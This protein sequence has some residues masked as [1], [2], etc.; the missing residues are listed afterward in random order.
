MTG[1]SDERV[2]ELAGEAVGRLA[3]GLMVRIASTELTSEPPRPGLTLAVEGQISIAVSPAVTTDIIG[4]AVSYAMTARP[5]TG[6]Q[7]VDEDGETLWGAKV[8]VHGQWS[9]TDV[10][11][12]TDD[13]MR[14]FAVKVGVM[15]LHPYARAQIQT[16]VASSGWPPYSMDVIQAP[17]VLFAGEDGL[18]DLDGVTMLKT[19]IG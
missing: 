14:A 5:T 6:D 2:H 4:C 10:A 19:A 9:V 15:A 3:P 12:L 7:V 13:H 16:V 1:V 11:D 8:V 18:I 17:E